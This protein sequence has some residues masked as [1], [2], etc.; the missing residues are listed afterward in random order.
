NV[1]AL[2]SYLFFKTGLLS[3]NHQDEVLSEQLLEDVKQR[4]KKEY[5][6]VLMVKTFIENRIE[7]Q[8][9]NEDI[10]MMTLFLSTTK[11][12][13]DESRIKAMIIAHG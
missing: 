12:S 5:Q 4:Y 10:I 13:H 9:G 6:I 2:S 1:Y 7:F 11:I 3:L 8:L